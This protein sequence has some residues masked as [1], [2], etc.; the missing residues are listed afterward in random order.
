[1]DALA[2]YKAGQL[3]PA[4][5]A[6]GTEL[7]KQ[8]GDIKRRTF[9]FE[10]LCFAGAYDRAEK[11]LDVLAGANKDALAGAM[12]YRAALHG[13]RTREELFASGQLP[14]PEGVGVPPGGMVNGQAFTSF[15]D[16][17]ER[18]GAHLE[19]FIAGSYTWVPFRYIERVEIAPPKRLR[20]LLWATAILT[21]TADFRL[22]DLGEVLIPVLAPGSAASPD[23]L[24]RLG[25][26]TIFD[27]EQ[28]RPLGQKIFLADG[29]E[30]PLLTVRELSFPRV[31]AESAVEATAGGDRVTV[32]ENPQEGR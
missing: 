32:P 6:L 20:D 9:L 12:L 4:I 17:D 2:L 29:V 13:Q 16:E 11:Q 21:T 23:D 19:V 31:A 27:E 7:R 24:V 25:R 26:T 22:Q 8:P 15:T 30:Y 18:I 3:G 10:L 5:E 1:M 14:I 28:G